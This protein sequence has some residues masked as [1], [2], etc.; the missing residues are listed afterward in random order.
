MSKEKQAI[1]ITEALSTLKLLDKKVTKK[2]QELQKSNNYPIDFKIGN[3][4]KGEYTLLTSEEL[5]KKAQGSLDS[6]TNIIKNRRTL[7]AKIALS[8]AITEVTIADT[9]MSIVE[10]IEYKNSIQQDKDLLRI[11]E[12]I[13]STIQGN[14]QEESEEAREK[15]TEL[16]NAKL[17][18]DSN[19]NSNSEVLAKELASIYNPTLMDPINLGS[20]IED[21]R[22]RIERFETDV[23]VVLSISNAN[24]FIDV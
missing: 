1:T 4:T 7:K 16:L 10:C 23:D 9:K 22:E 20:V 18:S 12:G 14:F 2:L 8:N 21:L 6:V 24:T 13:Y 17:S 11:L 5:Q 19:K 15:I 3:S